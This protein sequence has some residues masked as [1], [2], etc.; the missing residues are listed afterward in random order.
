MQRCVCAEY[1]PRSLTPRPPSAMD[2]K[3]QERLLL[4]LSLP[5][6]QQQLLQQQPPSVDRQPKRRR[7]MPPLLPLAARLAFQHGCTPACPA[8]A[9]AAPQ[10]RTEF[11]GSPVQG[12]GGGQGRKLCSVGAAL[13][14]S[15]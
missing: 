9:A 11:L 6:L 10:Q 3:E 13:V 7:L 8:W 14:G 5:Q 1:S 2:V 4:S 15:R 12:A